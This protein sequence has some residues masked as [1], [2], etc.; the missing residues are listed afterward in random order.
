MGN[1]GAFLILF[2]IL[3]LTMGLN[4][5]A[6]DEDRKVYIVYLGAIP[7]VSY[8][9]SSHH[10]SI[11]RSVIQG[12]FVENSL[13]RSYTRSFNG[14]VAKLTDQE[15]Q[16]LASNKEV[17]SIF[18][19]NIFHTQTTR[20]WDFIGLKDT[21]NRKPTV[22]SDTIVGVIDTGIWP[23]SES[24]NDEDFGPPPKKW[25]GAC[26]GGQNFTCNNKLIGARYYGTSSDIASAWDDVGHG[27]HTAS[28][29]AG[30]H[31][32]GA[33]FYGIAKGTARGGVPSARIAAYKVCDAAGCSSEALFAAFDDAIADGVDI[34]TISIGSNAAQDFA[35]DPIAIGAFHA[36]VKGILTLNSAGNNGPDP[37]SVSSVAP[38]MMSVAASSTD[39][40]IVD[41]V[42][43]D[44]GM[45]LIG[46][47]VNSFELNFTL[48]PLVHGANASTKCSVFSAS[49]CEAGC[50]DKDLVKGKI[51]LCDSRDGISEAY[52]AG[53]VGLI[54]ANDRAGDV[55]FIVPLPA[56]ALENDTYTY[57]LDYIRRSP[58]PAQATILKSEAKIDDS[59][60]RVASFSSRG[61]NAITPDILKPDI[62]APG[63]DILASYSLIVPPSSF[64]QDKRRVKFNIESGTSMSCPHVAG[65]AAYVKTFHPDWSPSAIG[66][67]LMTTAWLMNKT[68]GLSGEFDY[69]SGHVNP[70]Q[71]INPGLVYDAFEADYI[72]FLCSIGLDDK[73]V[74]LISGHKSSCPEG[75]EPGS[76]RD[77]NYPSMA[78]QVSD[79]VQVAIKFHRRVKN[80]GNSNSTYKASIFPKTKFDIKV[81][82]S[83]LSFKSLNEEKSFDVIVAGT[84]LPLNSMVSTSLVWSDGI[85]SVGSPI[86]LHNVVP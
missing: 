24:F 60:P 82:P 51:V 1:Y 17:V 44:D 56:V 29:A 47:S 12:S 59:A 36:M 76:P 15:K 71:A 86:V 2:S 63:V 67:S 62:S 45:T 4:C 52:N 61:P 30:N 50:L 75:S 14:F 13:V 40:R 42:V 21:S 85:H 3:I 33:S 35:N 55:S 70:V 78:A 73:K 28:T 16:K 8:S 37:G 43:L 72:K 6:N 54:Y 53:A 48:F 10:L 49:S 38:W 31:V 32:K 41:N 11:L 66:S 39:R 58:S 46:N 80:V 69:G 18:P 79:G 83:V 77:L 84:G 20:S 22:E 9:P 68:K 65:A 57:V 34:I 81:K 25:K 74:R 26:K 27:T 19:N 7:D 5:K 23:E 64:P